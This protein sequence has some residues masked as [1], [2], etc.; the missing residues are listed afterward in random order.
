MNIQLLYWGLF[1]LMLGLALSLPLAAVHYQNSPR[2]TSL[3][4]NPRKLKSAHLDF[5]TQA[6]AAA[7]VYVIEFAVQKAFPAHVVIPL[8]FGTVCNPLLL[9]LEA[10]PLH[11]EGL[12]KPFYRL[13]K[14]V[15]PVSLLLAWLSI[16]WIV[17]PASMAVGW[18]AFVLLGLWLMGSYRKR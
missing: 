18:A 12:G 1:S 14:A 7:F 5:F 17:L 13:L 3:F 16:A 11:R 2:W 6:F 15:S 4:T 9:L 8:L 10:T